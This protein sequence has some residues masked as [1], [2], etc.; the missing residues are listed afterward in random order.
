MSA[1]S[2]GSICIGLSCTGVSLVP[3]VVF[4]VGNVFFVI[5]D[6]TGKPSAML[7]YKIQ[8]EKAVPVS[9]LLHNIEESG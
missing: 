6:L 5:L 4:V 1:D 3:F 7:K 9:L 8:E 2:V